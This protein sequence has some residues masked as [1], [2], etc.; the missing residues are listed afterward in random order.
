M[1]KLGL[2]GLNQAGMKLGQISYLHYHQVFVR[3]LLLAWLF[4]LK[5][6]QVKQH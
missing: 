4:S 1:P 6:K 5:D 3:H 2:S